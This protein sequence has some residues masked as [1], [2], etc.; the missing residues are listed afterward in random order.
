MA[1]GDVQTGGGFGIVRAAL[2]I[3]TIV[4]L[5]EEVVGPIDDRLWQVDPVGH[6]ADFLEGRYQGPVGTAHRAAILVF[7]GWK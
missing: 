7:G 1:A 4:Y 3:F 5:L 6:C 2:Q